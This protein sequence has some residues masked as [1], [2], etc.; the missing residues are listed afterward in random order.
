M[1]VQWIITLIIYIHIFG[2]HKKKYVRF[3]FI[4]IILF[5]VPMIQFTTSLLAQLIVSPETSGAGIEPRAFI[6]MIAWSYVNCI[7]FVIFYN[8]IVEYLV[9]YKDRHKVLKILYITLVV[10][11]TLIALSYKFFDASKV[12]K[13][14][15][16]TSSSMEVPAVL[17]NQLKVVTES[18]GSKTLIIEGE[19]KQ[20]MLGEFNRH[21]LEQKGNINKVAIFSDGGEIDEALKIGR[22]IRALR[23]ATL[24]PIGQKELPKCDP[25]YQIKET[26]C[27]CNS[28]CFFIYAGGVKRQGSVIGV[29]R[30]Y[31]KETE[32]QQ[33]SGSVAMSLNTNSNK[34]VLDYLKSMSVPHSIIDKVLF[35]QSASLSFLSSDDLKQLNGFI[36]ELKEWVVSKCGNYE[37]KL[38]QT[39]LINA[40]KDDLKQSYNEAALNAAIK[41]AQDELLLVIECEKKISSDIAKEA[42]MRFENSY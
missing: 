6:R 28:A 36:P 32:L 41:K 29:H 42:F 3:L 5:I 12:K 4:P 24:V 31:I 25:I 34:Q 38:G 40:F 1:I 33:M 16:N 8:K 7:I 26:N 23:L 21:I 39:F 2:F 9:S 11:N 22:G 17:N 35:T 13:I 19:I 18:S 20:G 27:R 37:E 15:L 14:N 10:L 30:P